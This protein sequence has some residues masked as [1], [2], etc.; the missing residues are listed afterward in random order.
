LW[1]LLLTRNGRWSTKVCKSLHSEDIQVAFSLSL[2]MRYRVCNWYQNCTQRF[3]CI[4]LSAEVFLQCQIPAGPTGCTTPT[5]PTN[6]SAT[7]T[8]ATPVVSATGQAGFELLAATQT[9]HVSASLTS[10]SYN[11]NQLPPTGVPEP[12]SVAL[13]GIGLLGIRGVHRRLKLPN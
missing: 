12:S 7:G 11:F 9:G 2:S 1:E 13:L 3:G 10:V 5:G 4:C 6:L 8:L